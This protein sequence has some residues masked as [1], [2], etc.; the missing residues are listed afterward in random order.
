MILSITVFHDDQVGNSGAD[1]AYWGRAEDM[2]M[3]RPAYILT[4]S[5]PGS[6]LAAETAAAMAAGYIVFKQS[7]SI[8]D[9]H[10]LGLKES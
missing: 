8:Y 3:N 5:N 9:I 4:T 7:G 6:D 1:H 2:T 10:T